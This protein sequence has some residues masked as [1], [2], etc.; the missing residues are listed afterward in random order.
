MAS[1]EGV[2][3]MQSCQTFGG[4][5]GPYSILSSPGLQLEECVA[6]KVVPVSFMALAVLIVVDDGLCCCC[7][8]Y[9]LQLGWAVASKAQGDWV[10]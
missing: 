8:L 4:S 2:S 7:C 6:V 10:V 5:L 1:Q 3:G 9:G